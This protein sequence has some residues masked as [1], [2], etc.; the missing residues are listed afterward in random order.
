VWLTVLL[1]SPWRAPE[2]KLVP[3]AALGSLF[4]ISLVTGASMMTVERLPVPSW[5]TTV[6]L[7]FVS[8]VFDNIPLTKL[9]LEQGGYD[10]GALA[11][12]VGFGGSMV[13][14]GSSAGVALSTQFPQA[15]SVFLWLRYGWT[16]P[17]AYLAGFAVLLVLVGWHP[18]PA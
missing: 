17:L 16:I 4:L 8:A 9:A 5:Q 6:G 18:A 7:G 14:F 1:T 12:A 3:P 10:W 13:W 2:W 15:K 11:F